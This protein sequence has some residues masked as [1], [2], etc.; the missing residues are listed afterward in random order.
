MWTVPHLVS[1]PKQIN[2]KMR[3]HEDSIYGHNENNTIVYSRIHRYIFKIHIYTE[4]HHRF[5]SIHTSM[6]TVDTYK[7]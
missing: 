1:T 4:K 5:I 7:V 2:I 6:H 3:L